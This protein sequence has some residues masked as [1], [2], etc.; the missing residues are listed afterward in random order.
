MEITDRADIGV[1]LKAPQSDLS[2]S[3]KWT[4]ALVREVAEGDAVLH[5]S[6]PRRALVGW[7]IADGEVW[8][9]PI[10]WAAHGTSS[11]SAGIVPHPQPGLRRAL[12]SYRDLTAPITKDAVE[13]QRPHIEAVKHKLTERYGESLYFPF[14][15]RRGDT[16]AAQGYL[17]KF[18][19]ELLGLW[20]QLNALSATATAG[21]AL[22]ADDEPHFGS[23][24]RPGDEEASAAARQPFSVDPDLVDRGTRAHA[25]TQNALASWVTNCGFA[26]LS[27]NGEPQFD[28]AWRAGDRT[29]V[30]EVKSLTPQNEERQLRLGLGQVLRYR[31]LLA[32]N[33]DEV[34]AVLMVERAPSDERWEELCAALDVLLISPKTL[35][36]L[37]R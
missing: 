32:S 30:A 36:R 35:Q 27:P 26:P 34:H 20:P 19:L 11:R 22:S 33:G 6:T 24:Y 13:K 25:R 9:E 7:S 5:W 2:G 15:L 21:A 23:R 10:V 4:Y 37:P 29:Y 12:T 18:P 3:P 14:Q 16:R 31:Q 28:L 1:D 8:E 17:V